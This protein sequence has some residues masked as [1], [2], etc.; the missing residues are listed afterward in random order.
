VHIISSTSSDTQIIPRN[1]EFTVARHTTI[2]MSRHVTYSSTLPTDGRLS[3]V[4]DVSTSRANTEATIVQAESEQLSANTIEMSENVTDTTAATIERKQ[5]THHSPT[6]MCTLHELA[7]AGLRAFMPTV[8]GS[9]D[10]SPPHLE[11]ITTADIEKM[12]A[13]DKCPLFKLPPELR[14]AIYA[15]TIDHT[16]GQYGWIET[17][18]GPKISLFNAKKCAPSNELLRTCRRAYAEGRGIFVGAQRDFWSK[19]TFTFGLRHGCGHEDTP[20]RVAAWLD[21]LCEEQV[22]S[23]THLTIKTHTFDPFKVHLSATD[24][25]GPTSWAIEWNTAHASLTTSMDFGKELKAYFLGLQFSHGRCQCPSTYAQLRS[26]VYPA[27]YDLPTYGR[28]MDDDFVP[29]TGACGLCGRLESRYPVVLDTRKGELMIL[30]A[31]FCYAHRV[32]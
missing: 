1:F 30:V 5:P 19:T 15:Y 17:Q 9:P 3:T 31:W 26:K 27:I 11:T 8:H 25:S 2:N 12:D 10:K 32:A 22:N 16:D 13:Q 28:Y 14:N 20:D 29:A 18:D 6:E 7:P 21:S 23:I 4:D 24:E